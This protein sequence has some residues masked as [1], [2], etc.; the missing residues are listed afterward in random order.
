MTDRSLI[1]AQMDLFI[2][3]LTI[4]R[5]ASN[6]PPDAWV[7]IA[8]CILN[9]AQRP[10][11]WGRNVIEV[12][13]KRE[14]FTSMNTATNDPNLRRWPQRGDKVFEA[15]YTTVELTLSGHSQHPIPGA[16]SY[17]DESREANPPKWARDN[18]GRYRGK[19]GAF[20]FYDMDQ[21]YEAGTVPV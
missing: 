7:G 11:W 14:Q 16:D 5:E 6:Q 19:I 12:C 15:I 13:T 18:P 9:R 10:S 2:T 3:A 8:H 21:D 17:Y 4:W 1:W 20:Y